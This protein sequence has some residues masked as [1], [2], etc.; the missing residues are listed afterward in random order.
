MEGVTPST[1]GGVTLFSRIKK[2]L[3]SERGSIDIWLALT[4]A[5]IILLPTFYATSQVVQAARLRTILQQGAKMVSQ[6]ETAS[7]GY[8]NNVQ[9]ALTNYV[10]SSGLNPDR[11][12]VST[13]PGQQ[14]Y[15]Q[16]NMN[17]VLGY[18]YDVVFPG[19]PWTIWHSYVQ[20]GNP[21]IQSDYV[22]GA[23]DA[24]IASPDGF[25]GTEGG[26][27]NTSPAPSQPSTIVNSV[28][29]SLNPSS[30]QAGQSV[31]VSGQAL[32]GSNPPPA[33]TIVNIKVSGAGINVSGTTDSGGNYSA[34]FTMKDTGTYTVVASCGIGTSSQQLSVTPSAAS[35]IQLTAPQSVTVGNDLQ[36]NGQITD[37]FGN[38]VSGVVNVTS[39]DQADIPSSPPASPLTATNGSF[40][41]TVNQVT[42]SPLNSP[43]TITFT[44]GSTSAT[45]SISVLPGVPQSITL[46]SSATTITAG[47][48]VTFTGQVTSV[49]NTPVAAN[50][51]VGI[52]DSSDTQDAFP[53]TA[54]TDQ[55]G[56]YSTSPIA[57]TL[58]GTQ[59]V[60]ASVTE[61]GQT[62][63]AV[64][65][66][67]VDPAAPAK[68]E[69]LTANPNPVFQGANTTV[70]G[71][72]TDQYGNPVPGATVTLNSS[73][74][75]TPYTTITTA[76]GTFNVG[77]VFSTS[78][79]QTLSVEYNGQVLSPG[80]IQVS[81]E[82]QGAYLVTPQPASQNITAGQ[83]VSLSFLVTSSV[84]SLVADA[85]V[86]FSASPVSSSL[87]IT[88]GTTNEQ[89][90]VTLTVTPD[91]SGITSVTAT[92]A[93]CG[94]TAKINV[95]AA[96]PYQITSIQVTPSFIQVNPS[97]SDWPVTSGQVLDQYGNPVV[98][99]SITASGGYGP[100][101]TGTTNANGVFSI[102]IDPTNV[103]GPYY[104][105]VQ[106]SDSLGGV[107]AVSGTGL[108]VVQYPPA[109]MEIS[110][111]NPGQ[112]IYTGQLIPMYC[113]LYN[114][115]MQLWD[116]ATVEFVTVTDNAAQILNLT[117]SGP[118]G[119]GTGSLQQTTGTYGDGESAAEVNFNQSGSQ[120]VLAELY[121]N[122]N[123]T[124]TVAALTVTV[125]PGAVAQ[126]AWNPAQP[127]TTVTA[128]TTLTVSG[129]ALNS[130]GNPVPNGTQLVVQM[131]GANAQTVYTS[132]N[133]GQMGCFSASLTP[134]SSGSWF[135]QAAANGQTFTYGSPTP[136]IVTSGT[137]AIASPWG[138][139][140][141]S[142]YSE[143]VIGG[144]NTYT[145]QNDYSPGYQEWTWGVVDQYYNSIYN[146]NVNISISCTVLSGGPAP[147]S[148]ISASPNTGSQ[149]IIQTQASYYFPAGQYMLQV[150][151]NTTGKIASDTYF[152]VSGSAA[153]P[154]AFTDLVF[155]FG[156][157][158]YGPYTG[159][160][161][162]Y[163]NP[164][165]W[166]V[167]A[168]TPI[169]IIGK[170]VSSSG[171]PVP[172]ALIFYGFGG[173]G[174]GEGGVNTDSSGNF[175]VTVIPYESGIGSVSGGYFAW[176][177]TGP[178]S[179]NQ[180]FTV[181]PSPVN[182]NGVINV[183]L[184]PPTIGD[185]DWAV[186]GARFN[187]LASAFDQYGNPVNGNITLTTA[188]PSVSNSTPQVFSGTLINGSYEFSGITVG[189]GVN[190]N[191]QLTLT[192]TDQYG[193]TLPKYAYITIN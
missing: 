59:P 158:Q 23:I 68:V 176:I 27:G 141:F 146:A 151:N 25:I 1:F 74:F 167:Q 100:E 172:N 110:L 16:D 21:Q 90:V 5:M 64:A 15:G 48:S 125:L 37:Q 8:T 2:R 130:L 29:S 152:T 83:T 108:T 28:T 57:M 143:A 35:Q 73:G 38:P 163:T 93:G 160:Y 33:G 170:L 42:L 159:D 134:V 114:Q 77:V 166:V 112:T 75:A 116:N 142:N 117:P 19:T 120:T 10:T 174:T 187:V 173:T 63:N 168:G 97:Q 118:T 188:I 88:S 50:T 111:V 41:L 144:I 138:Q 78:G 175:T 103:G 99:A 155:S 98:G 34:S 127:G 156:G 122:G 135:L 132:T 109:T 164:T 13:T 61:N 139:D 149:S 147:F 145:A 72:V 153:I 22:P 44:S 113:T 85:P 6:A 157:Q 39:N 36:I 133:G 62:I 54:Q 52:G 184:N 154:Y 17:V 4:I 193:D 178:Q 65:N 26:K 69:N 102:S 43:L 87:S 11:V 18:D 185:Q 60:N 161:P 24:S 128:G 46:T 76:T 58:A 92:V 49:A 3:A 171:V 190:G 53:V 9:T 180:P 123:F 47:Q 107:N 70:T 131:P 20:S 40:Q 86:T 56:N 140:G 189:L 101:E 186:Q 80:G 179:W 51:N 14:G 95:A 115:N 30:V 91:T 105:T 182:Q 55:N 84:G 148:T 192:V 79:T 81:V 136:I 66:V 12:Y 96:A 32:E 45:A 71:K 177:A 183:D 165:T 89:G 137:I 191:Y 94:G 150:K 126:I 124:G 129:V 106:A 67:V 162:S 104:I 31:T 121:I 7:G 169:T 119:S 82:E 181:T